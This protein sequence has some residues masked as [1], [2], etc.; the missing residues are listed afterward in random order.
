LSSD[1]TRASNKKAREAR[2]QWYLDLIAGRECETCGESDPV[3]LDWHHTD[4]SEK[5]YSVSRMYKERGREAILN[6]I[7]KC[8]CLCANCHRKLHRDLREQLAS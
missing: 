8:Q 5:E 2:R 3:T 4:P 7:S 1:K 6:E